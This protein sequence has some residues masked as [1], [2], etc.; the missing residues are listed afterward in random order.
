[1]LNIDSIQNGI[2][3][4][5]ITAGTGMALY[6]LLGLEKLD[7]SIAIIRNARSS[8]KTGKKD[9]IKIEGENLNLDWDVLGY[10]DPEI[11]INVIQDGKIVDKKRPERPQRLVN[12]VRCHNPRCITS[13]EEEID[14]IFELTDS[15]KYRCIYCEEELNVKSR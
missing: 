14:H 11:T 9:I 7:C 6:Q 5:H 2:V 12:V 3:I 13:I 10:L 1:M 15:G 4:D 8:R